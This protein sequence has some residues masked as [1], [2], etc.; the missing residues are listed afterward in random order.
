ME[1][2]EDKILINLENKILV[3][4]NTDELGVINGDLSTNDILQAIIE[5]LR[6][7]DKEKEEDLKKQKEKMEE[8]F[9]KAIN[10][11]QEDFEEEYVI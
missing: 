8:K 9:S 10:R 3:K 7:K 1:K 11:V 6:Q 2:E 4:H 5:A